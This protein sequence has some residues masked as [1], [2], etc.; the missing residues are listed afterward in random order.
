M[1][2]RFRSEPLPWISGARLS[3]KKWGLF[4]LNTH[5]RDFVGQEAYRF[6]MVATLPKPVDEKLEESIERALTNILCA[7]GKARYVLRIDQNGLIQWIFYTDL[8]NPAL[9]TVGALKNEEAYSSLTFE[10]G[11]DPEW[12]I[13]REYAPAPDDE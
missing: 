1:S 10:I 8:L 4:L 6:R 13:Y 11:W 5:E 7:D 9:E 3:G 12:T 2:E